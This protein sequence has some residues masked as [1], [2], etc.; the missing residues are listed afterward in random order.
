MKQFIFK[1]IFF[2]LLFY[3]LI[4]FIIRD[5]N[6]KI[7]F[8]NE[9][10]YKVQELVKSAKKSKIIVLA[11]DSRAERQL[12]P[13]LISEKVGVKCVNLGVSSGELISFLP[14]L[15][16]FNPD[17]TFFVFSVSSFQIN[18]KVISPGYLSLD[19]YNAFNFFERCYLYRS[20]IHELLKM[21]QQLIKYTFNSLFRRGH[22]F[23]IPN[24]E[25]KMMILNLGYLKRDCELKRNYLNSLFRKNRHI[26]YKDVY[27][28]GNKLKLFK[29]AINIIAARGYKGIFYQPPICPS[30]KKIIK[31][32]KIDRTEINFS[33]ILR[34]CT[35]KKKNLYF[36]DFYSNPLI[37]FSDTMFCD[38]QHLN[39]QGAIPF[40]NLIS[41]LIKQYYTIK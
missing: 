1:V 14:Y 13:R 33:N 30:W 28:Y 23:Y 37:I 12:I 4:Y 8:N 35:K 11:G 10:E 25:K 20:N 5:V 7:G 41:E 22:N 39:T 17:S 15:K 40:S 36:F 2:C 27:L 19:A 24:K 26:W 9:L 31:N 38:A 18:D 6:K 21:E 29:N 3:F 34:Q 32:S 16:L